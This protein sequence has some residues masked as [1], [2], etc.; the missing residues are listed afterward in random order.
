MRKD[1]E[2]ENFRKEVLPRYQMTLKQKLDRAEKLQER[3]KELR[4]ELRKIE[5]ELMDL[6][7]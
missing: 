1:K 2:I 7:R 6:L 4:I 3:E 5:I